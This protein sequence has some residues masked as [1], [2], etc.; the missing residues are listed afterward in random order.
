MV[1]V[2][3]LE[4][5]HGCSGSDPSHRWIIVPGGPPPAAHRYPTMVA[6]R[7][8]FAPRTRP[9]DRAGDGHVQG[10]V[11]R[12]HAQ[13]GGRSVRGYHARAAVDRQRALDHR[14]FFNA[15]RIAYGS[16]ATSLPA[17]PDP[18][19]ATSGRTARQALP[20]A[21][22]LRPHAA[23]KAE[24]GP[25]TLSVIDGALERACMA[26]GIAVHMYGT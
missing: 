26:H 14:R 4:A 5:G 9:P 25:V 22:A 7:C 20:A 3:R 2:G 12:S 24:A 13:A 15:S 17:S 8:R 10:P 1:L 11:D 19:P 23:A 6:V 21:T 16:P 18:M